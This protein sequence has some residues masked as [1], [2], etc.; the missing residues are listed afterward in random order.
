MLDQMHSA[1]VPDG[2]QVRKARRHLRRDSA[3]PCPRQRV[4]RPQLRCRE[5]LIHVFT[6]G[7]RLMN[8][9]GTH[10]QHRKEPR[11]A[12]LLPPCRNIAT[13]SL[14]PT[15]A[16]RVL[17]SSLREVVVPEAGHWIQQERPEAVNAAL[18]GFLR[19]LPARTPG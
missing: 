14:A 10:V 7:Q 1:S 17:V 18:L 19:E 13:R 3:R 15:D 5:H 12:A 2:T 9:A 4:L 8:G 11:D 6:D 16:M